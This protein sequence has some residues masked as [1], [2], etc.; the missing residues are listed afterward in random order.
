MAGLRVVAI[1]VAFAF[2]SGE[3]ALGVT[4]TENWDLPALDDSGE[5]ITLARFEGTPTV[6]TFF[7]TWCHICQQ[8]LPGFAQLEVAVGDQVNFVGINTMNNGSGLTFAHEM[9]IGSW[10]LARDVGLGDGRQ[11]AT[12]FGAR[13]SPTTVL[14]DDEGNGVDVTLGGLTAEQLEVKLAQFFG[15]RN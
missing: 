1:V 13:G 5:M 14:Y 2:T 3:P 6:A 9:G 8:E 4:G 7:A 12:N 15:V 10:P 11:L